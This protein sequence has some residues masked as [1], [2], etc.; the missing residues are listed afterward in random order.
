MEKLTLYSYF[1]SSA[2]YRV[3]I[4][5]NLKGLP[6][7]TTYI[8]LIKDGGQQHSEAYRQ[9][10]PQELVPALTIGS[11]GILTQSLAIIEYLE[12]SHA[13]PSL[14]PGTAAERAQIRAFALAI[15][16]DIHPLNNLRVQNY[17]KNKLN[18]SDSDKTRWL[19]HWMDKGFSALEQQLSN[20]GARRCF[21][22]G[23]TPTL[24]DVCLIPQIYN[25][26]RFK[27]P[28]DDYSTLK[29]IYQHCIEQEAFINAS[30]DNQ[31]DS[32]NYKEA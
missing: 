18:V 2:A 9:L 19:H 13:E 29:R 25:A 15:S 11:T 26:L 1:R 23:N 28:L 27:L 17:L 12:E 6:H 22:F 10:N 24:A 7:D 31:P 14:L 21:C 5:L 20:T 16:C 4:A 8:N 32:P 3:R 30:P